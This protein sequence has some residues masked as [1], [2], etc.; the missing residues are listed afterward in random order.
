MNFARYTQ[1]LSKAIQGTATEAELGLISHYEKTR[2]ET[3]PKCDCPAHSR[4]EPTN[5]VVHDVENCREGSTKK[6]R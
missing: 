4:F 3:C 5:R 1:L 2:P 6:I